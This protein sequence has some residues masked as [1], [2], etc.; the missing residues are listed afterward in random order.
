MPDELDKVLSE[1]EHDKQVQDTQAKIAQDL[2]TFIE[3]Y[4]PPFKSK[5]FS[6][7]EAYMAFQLHEVYEILDSAYPQEEE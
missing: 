4:Y 7:A 5:G 3:E 2:D 6:I 1:I